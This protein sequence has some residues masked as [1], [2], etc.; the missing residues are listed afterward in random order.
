MFIWFLRL[1]IFCHRPSNLFCQINF[2]SN[3]RPPQCREV[4]RTPLYYLRCTNNNWDYNFSSLAQLESVQKSGNWNVRRKKGRRNP[5]YI[6]GNLQNALKTSIIDILICEFLQY[7]R[8]YPLNLWKYPKEI[9]NIKSLRLRKKLT[10]NAG[11][12]NSN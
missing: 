12:L 10:Q 1:A 5:R 2:G 4:R 6:Y 9:S 3:W 7:G 8:V 11:S